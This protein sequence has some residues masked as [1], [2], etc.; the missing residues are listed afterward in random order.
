MHSCPFDN[1]GHYDGAD[2]PEEWTPFDDDEYQVWLIES[3][4]APALEVM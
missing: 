4:Q 2:V 1:S 3:N